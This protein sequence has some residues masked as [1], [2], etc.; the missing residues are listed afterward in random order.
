MQ[1]LKRL[2]TWQKVLGAAAVLGGG[3]WLYKSN[4]KKAK[5]KATATPETHPLPEPQEPT[6][7]GLGGS[8]FPQPPG[9]TPP[10]FPY[11]KKTIKRR[12]YLKSDNQSMPAPVRVR[13]L[14][15]QNGTFD[16]EFRH[17]VGMETFT[18]HTREVADLR[19]ESMVKK[20]HEW[21]TCT[22]VSYDSTFDGWV[23]KAGYAVGDMVA[24]GFHDTERGAAPWFVA[25]DGNKFVAK[26]MPDL[27]ATPE[28]LG[29]YDDLFE[30]VQAA[31]GA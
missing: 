17:Q 15:N 24:R 11:G 19:F 3:W 12:R 10:E 20:P 23:C 8:G 25:W 29:S 14:D 31:S 16:V 13:M 21:T 1:T 26:F 27:H 18:H 4:E 7:G 5:A 6:D 28:S 22:D 2:P 9:P 30:A